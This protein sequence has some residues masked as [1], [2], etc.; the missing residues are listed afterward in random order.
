MNRQWRMM[1]NGKWQVMGS[2][3]MWHG[4]TMGNSGQWRMTGNRK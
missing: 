2:D 1:D 4:Q 3:R